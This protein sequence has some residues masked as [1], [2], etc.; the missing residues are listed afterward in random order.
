MPNTRGIVSVTKFD[1]LTE[2][3]LSPPQTSSRDEKNVRVELKNRFLRMQR[4][5]HT[6]Q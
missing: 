3:L 5:V 1:C 2:K 6:A 4:E